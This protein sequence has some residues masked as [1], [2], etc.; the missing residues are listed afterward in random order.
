MKEVSTQ[1]RLGM[2]E[3]CPGLGPC[4]LLA[5]QRVALLV[6]CLPWR[7]LGFHRPCLP[8]LP[9][10]APAFCP[11]CSA[12]GPT[13]AAVAT[14]KTPWR[15]GWLRCGLE[16][17][18][19]AWAVGTSS[20]RAWTPNAALASCL[21]LCS[22]IAAL[23]GPCPLFVAL[24]LLRLASP[25]VC[26]TTPPP[27][28]ATTTRPCSSTPR[29]RR[30]QPTTWPPTPPAALRAQPRRLQR[31]QRRQQLQQQPSL[32]LSNKPLLSRLPLRRQSQWHRRPMR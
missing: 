20:W 22:L 29:W 3:G 2:Q 14:R 17:A 27:T 21:P 19:R 30:R 24:R 23:V 12:S 28:P 6:R 25:P 8:A 5:A 16:A 15:S 18:G 13:T 10:P 9:A 32:H 7:L 11:R 4:A 26:R 31:R 1:R